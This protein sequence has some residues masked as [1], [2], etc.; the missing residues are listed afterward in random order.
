MPSFGLRA[1]S[2]FAGDTKNKVGRKLSLIIK[3]HSSLRRCAQLQRKHTAPD[4]PVLR[5]GRSSETRRLGARGPRRGPAVGRVVRGAR[6]LRAES[7][8]TTIFVQCGPSEMERG[9][10]SS[11]AQH[12]RARSSLKHVAA[13]PLHL[14]FASPQQ[15]L[16]RCFLWRS[17]SAA[18]DYPGTL[19]LTPSTPAPPLFAPPSPSSTPTPLLLRAWGS[20]RDL[21]DCSH[22]PSVQIIM[23][24]SRQ[25]NVS[26][27]RDSP[28]SLAAAINAAYAKRH[29]YKFSYY[30]Y[31]STR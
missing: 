9:L 19:A 18:P 4:A 20:S 13:W 14:Q 7:R 24:D 17:H 11:Q 6:A 29:G 10:S 8:P 12:S 1:S 25:P 3:R 30:R 16:P 22:A 31:V 28:P 5:A 27:P 26:V 23:S 2:P 15:Q 21:S